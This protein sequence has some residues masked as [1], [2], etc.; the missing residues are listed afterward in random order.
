M[1]AGRDDV[2]LDGVSIMKKSDKNKFDPGKEFLLLSKK[3][4]NCIVSFVALKGKSERIALVMWL[5]LPLSR[6]WR[7]LTYNKQLA[8]QTEG[9]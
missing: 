2:W 4:E 5:G 1:T 3:L 7:L 6:V 8:L 9:V